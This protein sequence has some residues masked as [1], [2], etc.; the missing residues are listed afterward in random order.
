MSVQRQDVCIVC[1]KTIKECHKD[2]A[3]KKCKMYV[4]KKCTKM[5]PKE[6][7]RCIEWTCDKCCETTC[8]DMS[9]I[10]VECESLINKYNVSDI[11]LESKF[12]NMCFNPLRYESIEKN[13]IENDYKCNECS[14]MTPEQ[15]NSNTVENNSAFTCL[16]VNVRSIS[17]NFEKLKECLKATNH[18]FTVIGLSE[19]HLKG[20]PPEYYNLSGYKMEYVNRVGR[21]KGGVCMYVSNKVKYKTRKDLCIANS[22]YESCFIEIERKNAK[23]ILV[24]VVYRAHTSIDNFTSDID[25]VFNKMNSE[26]KITYVMGD[27][28]IDLLK[29][30]TNR[31]IHDY[32]DLI[33][34]Y[35]LIP[36]IYKPTRIT[37][38][39]A[40]LIDNILTNSENVQKSAIFVTDISDHMP[41]ALVSN[42]SFARY[43]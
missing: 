27:F 5:K 6:L 2:I 4:H 23:N 12:K 30:D 3:C 19:T 42:L 7:K 26:N 14:Y 22:D 28:N 37:K 18:D 40:T 33:Y 35:S 41:T 9:N 11:D 15:F 39:T 1:S 43:G 29:D 25:K 20:K 21:G 10:E 8:N 34:S 17:K 36:T 31:P 38:T 24:G 16:N 13:E 32:I